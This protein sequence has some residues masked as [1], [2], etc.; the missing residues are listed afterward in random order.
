MDAKPQLT[1]KHSRTRLIARDSD[2]HYVECLE[3]GEILEAEEL[4]P[5][6]SREAPGFDE[7]LSDA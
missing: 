1:C 7:S 6:E 5:A 3:C 2:A 4:K